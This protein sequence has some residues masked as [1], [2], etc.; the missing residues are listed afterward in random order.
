MKNYELTYI[1]PANLAEEE[2]KGILEKISSLIQEKGGVLKEGGIPVKRTLPQQVKGYGEV[3]SISIN[4]YVNPDKTKEIG[5]GINEEKSVLRSM[6]VVKEAVSAPKHQRKRI[7]K[8]EPEK[9]ADL[10]DIGNKIDE[11]FKEEE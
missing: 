9:K 5:D 10:E 11:I 1:L 2:Q 7:A 3:V 6:L 4:F 8:E